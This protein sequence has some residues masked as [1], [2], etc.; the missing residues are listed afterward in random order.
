MWFV[1]LMGVG[2]LIIS[3]LAAALLT[4]EIDDLAAGTERVDRFQTTWD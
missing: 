1:L 3:A 4:G 2:A